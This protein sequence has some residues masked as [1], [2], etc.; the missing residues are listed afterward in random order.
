MTK[1][2]DEHH[3]ALDDRHPRRAGRGLVI[4]SGV[5]LAGLVVASASTL[6]LSLRWYDVQDL[7]VA[8]RHAPALRPVV[9]LG[10]FV[11][12][13]ASLEA[14]GRSREYAPLRNKEGRGEIPSEEKK[15]RRS[16]TNP[17]E[18]S[19]GKGGG[20]PS[21]T[22]E[23][24]VEE[25][26]HPRR[27]KPAA[28]RDASIAAR[29]AHCASS[30]MGHDDLGRSLLFRLLPGVVVSLAIGLA[31]A[32]MS[33]V[34]GATWGMVAGLIGGRVDLVM[35]RV[36]DVLY[37]LPYILMVIL[38][39]VAVSKPLATLLGGDTRIADIVVLLIAIGGVSW[40]TMAR[41]VRGQ[42]LSLREQPFVEAARAAGAGPVHILR[43]HLL[44]NLVG[45]IVTYATLVIP[46]AILQ[47]SFLSF[48]G[49]GVQQPTPSLGRLAADGVEAV[50]T[51]VGY[52]WLIVYPC[53][54]LVVTLVALN[55][56]GDALRDR[57]DPKS[58]A[59]T[60]V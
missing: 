2:A 22:A 1:R 59:A 9:A 5:V 29:W 44:P 45:P 48:L 42:V 6:P 12:R 54:T 13:A 8:V 14:R 7:D 30:W 39:K 26:E 52:W 18:S 16:T 17:P 34:I 37:G 20:D 35:M 46:Q 11:D 3:R 23:P 10:R 55:F 53:G 38:L 41:V 21:E 24:G 47:E 4:A 15:P 56:L 32:G 49:I 43:R 51:F 36:V 60:L 50:N 28:Q 33:V 31:A 58:N 40:L 25:S 19:L 27:L 57:F